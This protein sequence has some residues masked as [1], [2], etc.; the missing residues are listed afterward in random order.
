MHTTSVHDGMKK[1]E[2]K[3]CKAKFSQKGHLNVHITSIHEH[4]KPVMC[5]ICS[6]KFAY[7]HHIKAHICN[8]NAVET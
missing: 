5:T 8:T 2:C 7:K 3:I 4:K 1:F 6:A